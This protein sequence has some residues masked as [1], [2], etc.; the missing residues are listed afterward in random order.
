MASERENGDDDARPTLSARSRS[1]DSVHPVA[2][3]PALSSSRLSPLLA[4][5]GRG[6]QARS[7]QL[8]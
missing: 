4:H 2:A 5:C 7:V 1:V 6:I 3:L 8:V